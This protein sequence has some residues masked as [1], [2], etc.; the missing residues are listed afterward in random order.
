MLIKDRYTRMYNGKK[1][2]LLFQPAR[3][4]CFHTTTSGMCSALFFAQLS[5]NVFAVCSLCYISLFGWI[6]FF[7]SFEES[8]W[9][10]ILFALSPKMS[11]LVLPKHKMSSQVASVKV[12]CLST[13][14]SKL[15][16][17]KISDIINKFSK[18]GLRYWGV[19]SR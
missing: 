9:V 10:L 4:N 15:R 19:I 16:L 8:I 17:Q 18:L 11:L 12:Y 2:V 7:L 6:S 5:A 14:C 13:T 3:P 1:E